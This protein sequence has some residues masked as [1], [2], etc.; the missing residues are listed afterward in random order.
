[1]TYVLWALSNK[2]IRNH[3][4]ALHDAPSSLW[5][6]SCYFCVTDAVLQF[7]SNL[8]SNMVSSYCKILFTKKEKKIPDKINHR[9]T[10]CL[11]SNQLVDLMK[12]LAAK[13]LY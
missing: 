6:S 9:Y 8:S 13:E 2:T 10:S 4:Q 5:S 3:Y 12:H 11:V 1:M 7:W